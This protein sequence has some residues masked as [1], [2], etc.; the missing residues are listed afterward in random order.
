MG[1]AETPNKIASTVMVYIQN[2]TYNASFP[3]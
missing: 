2:S 1:E 3:I